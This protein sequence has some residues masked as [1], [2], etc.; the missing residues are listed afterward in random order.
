MR[1]VF[2]G[3]PEFA[4][5]SLLALVG[6]GFE[7]AAV[8]T[9]PDKPQGRSRS[10]LIPSPV[11]S[12]AI[13]ES[14][15]VLQPERPKDPAF[16]AQ[17]SQL[18]PEIGVVVAYGHILSP[19]LLAV[20]RRG[21]V[22]VHPSLLPELRGAAPVEWAILNG[23]E[24]TGV[25]I[26]LMEAGLDSG[27]VLHQ[28]PHQLAPDVTGGELSAHLAEVGA[29]A[30]IE[31][32]AMMEADGPAPVPQ[33][34]ERATYAPKITRETGHVAWDRDAATIRRTILAL[35]PRPGA[36]T[37]LEGLEVKLFGA[38]PAPGSGTPGDV[39]RAERELVIAAGAGALAIS[40]VQP[41][42]K[43]RM[44]AVEWIRGRGVRAGQR[45]V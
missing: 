37:T 13:A 17:M 33:H 34:H 38:V 18:G 9:R 45:M 23:L 16:I 40:E 43:P 25:T 42:G 8:V 30:L 27:P 2:F 39:L 5:P 35:D 22:N 12:A 6:E 31:T 4:V 24:K 28:I 44:G 14:L 3:T 32:L 19:E 41:S 15:P 7:V 10:T 21:M 20:P 26:M 11:K 1:V 29:Q 36:W